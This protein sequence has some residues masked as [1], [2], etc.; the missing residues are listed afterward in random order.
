M[1]GL[2]GV[3]WAWGKGA[4]TV[5]RELDYDTHGNVV[6]SDQ[7]IAQTPNNDPLGLSCTTP[8]GFTTAPFSGEFDLTTP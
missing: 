5:V 3:S 6:G 8:Q 2:P 1:E 7:A 4:G